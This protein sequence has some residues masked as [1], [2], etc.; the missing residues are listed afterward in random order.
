MFVERYFFERPFITGPCR[1]TS[2]SASPPVTAINTLSIVLLEF[3]G[4][5]GTSGYPHHSDTAVQGH[6]SS[7]PT[8]PPQPL[9]IS[10]TVLERIAQPCVEDGDT[11]CLHPRITSTYDSSM[12]MDPCRRSW[13]TGKFCHAGVR[14]SVSLSNQAFPHPPHP[15]LSS[16]S[17]PAYGH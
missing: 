5:D 4:V 13:K 16:A 17:T 7:S 10:P 14:D 2:G 15:P 9:R 11:S 8:P 12:D 3:F 1:S 6:R